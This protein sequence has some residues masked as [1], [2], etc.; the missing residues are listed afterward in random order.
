[1]H[2][3]AL[4]TTASSSPECGGS[5]SSTTLDPTSTKTSFGAGSLII[6]MDSCNNPD[7]GGNTGPKNVNGTCSAGPSYTCYANY[8][9]GDDRLPFGVLYLLAENNIP[10]S[11]ILNTSQLGLTDEDFHVA[12]PAGSSAS[13][14]TVSKLAASSTGYTVDPAGMK[15]TLANNTVYYHGM[16]F[17]V[18]AS[19]VPQALQVITT[20][21]NNNSNLFSSVNLHIANYP[22]TAPVLAV[23]ASRPKPVLI[24]GSPLDT[25]FS[26]SGI[27]SVAA[28]NTTYLNISGSGSSWSGCPSH[29][30]RW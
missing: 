9:T 19:F 18:E 25:F 29:S 17:V 27:T 20:F 7:Q 15:S 26:E 24:D 1:M 13:V 4:A 8:T 10:V 14:P 12:P 22:F 21:N 5:V 23:L 6:P 30:R 11:V 28:A 3:D 16:P 2:G